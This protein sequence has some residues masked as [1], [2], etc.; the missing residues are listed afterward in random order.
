MSFR[1]SVHGGL[2]ITALPRKKRSQLW[3]GPGAYINHDCTPNC[4][5]VPNKQQTATINVLRDI[6]AGAEINCFYGDNFFGDE[7]C[8]CECL[9]CERLQRGAFA[10]PRLCRIITGEIDKEEEQKYKLRAT[11]YRMCR[12]AAADDGEG[13]ADPAVIN[14]LSM[15]LS[16]VTGVALPQ[17]MPN[18]TAKLARS[19]WNTSERR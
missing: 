16:E 6:K 4:E 1:R 17:R 5:F 18:S 3:L 9:T 11:S 2:Q 10:D 7:N 14:P 15:H 19:H 12:G 13:V 8:N